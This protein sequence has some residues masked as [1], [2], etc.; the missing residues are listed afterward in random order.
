MFINASTFQASHLHKSLL[1]ASH[2]ETPDLRAKTLIKINLKSG[3]NRSLCNQHASCWKTVKMV[4]TGRTKEARV[5]T[6]RMYFQ[7]LSEQKASKDRSIDKS[8]YWVWR[9]V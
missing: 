7:T 9:K 5:R 3:F 6:K 8:K 1:K 4:R 2:Q